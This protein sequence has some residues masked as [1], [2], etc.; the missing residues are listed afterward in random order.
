MDVE[1][2]RRILIMMDR[3]N[4]RQKERNTEK[5]TDVNRIWNGVCVLIQ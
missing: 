5:Q 1:I 2:D 3:V 4:D